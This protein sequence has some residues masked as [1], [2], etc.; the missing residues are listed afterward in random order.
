MTHTPPLSPPP[1]GRIAIA[2]HQPY[3]LIHWMI[4]GTLEHL[5]SCFLT[6]ASSSGAKS[7]LPLH[8]RAQK[9]HT[10]VAPAA[11]KTGELAMAKRRD[12][13][14][15]SRH[16]TSKQPAGETVGER[17]GA[18]WNILRGVD[19][20]VEARV[21]NE[22]VTRLEERYND[23]IVCSVVGKQ[24]RHLR[25]QHRLG[26][27]CTRNRRVCTCEPH[28]CVCLSVCPCLCTCMDVCVFVCVCVCVCLSVWTYASTER[29]L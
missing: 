16:R 8:E 23:E 19:E 4:L 15:A 2:K 14:H 12:R 18:K 25:H 13:E 9:I 20:A 29:N 27:I 10:W 6:R 22:R 24:R 11:V 26:F 5:C 28:L 3:T 21:G 1:N 7:L 17:C